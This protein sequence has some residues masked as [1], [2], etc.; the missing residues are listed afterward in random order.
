MDSKLMQQIVQF[1]RILKRYDSTYRNAAHKFD[2]P[3]L[4]LWILYVLRE[5]PVCTQKDLVEQLLQSKQSIHSALKNLVQDGYV[6]LEYP[7]GN[8]KYKN[9]FL[10]EKGID[11]VEKT[12][13]K[14]IRAEQSAFARFSEEEQ[15]TILK[16]ITRL[17]D[18][19][20]DEIDKNL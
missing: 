3:E 14:I 17:V 13:D 1:N 15:E 20:Q 12:A 10:T 8:H 18:T 9:I 11:L 5:N 19:L 2:L 16:L 6:V 7:P 4:A